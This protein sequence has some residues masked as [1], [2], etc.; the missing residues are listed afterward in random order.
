MKLLLESA[1]PSHASIWASSI[2]ITVEGN[3]AEEKQQA[4]TEEP[5]NTAIN[6]AETTTA[7]DGSLAINQNSQAPKAADTVA[8]APKTELPKPEASPV[9]ETPA[10]PTPAPDSPVVVSEADV[11]AAEKEND[12]HESLGEQIE[13]LTGEVQALEAKI[14]KLTSGVGETAVEPPVVKKDGETVLST[15][16]A[17]PPKDEEAAPVE[18]PPAPEKPV[19]PEVQKAPEPAPAP[20][21]V[22]P[23]A[24]TIPT[25]NT[26][27]PAKPVNDIYT[28]IL[29]GPQ[30][31]TPPQDHKDLNDEAT[32][33]EGTSGVGTIGEV[34]IVF[35][36]IALL[37]LLA[38]PFLKATLGSNWEAVKSI[39]WPTATISLGLGF[40][41]FLF[42]KGRAMFKLFAFVM[43]LISVVMLLAVF[44]YTSMLGP[45]SSFLD[46]IASFYK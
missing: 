10:A 17:E 6:G 42:N 41:L 43:L 24:A 26:S 38:S 3:M 11:A 1:L 21:P 13:V 9:L 31:Q 46:P 20:P 2:I 44:D 40:I 27:Q 7:N 45:L 32:I 19:E 14:E 8:P 23:P 16:P 25:S 37:G 22:A 30:G 29:S 28:K 12:P 35:G 18:A 33:E 39:G 4:K 34:L 5:K 36:L 15:P